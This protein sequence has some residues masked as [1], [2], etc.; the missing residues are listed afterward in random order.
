[1]LK[2]KSLSWTVVFLPEL[3][4]KRTFILQIEQKIMSG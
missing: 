2:L 1:M 3:K 4:A